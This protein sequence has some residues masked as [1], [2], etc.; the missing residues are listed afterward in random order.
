MTLF[1]F[2]ATAMPKTEQISVVVV[3]VTRPLLRNGGM[4]EHHGAPE[5]RQL[6]STWT[7]NCKETKSC[8]ERAVQ[9]VRSCTVQNEMR[10]V[11]ER[12]SASA[13]RRILDSANPREK[14]A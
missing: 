2:L 1:V 6:F 9:R 3:V 10:G 13:A 4:A 14:R 5:A 8:Q 12:V 7:R 11:L